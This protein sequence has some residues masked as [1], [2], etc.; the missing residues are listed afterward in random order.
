[1]NSKTCQ[2][3]NIISGILQL[4]YK[5]CQYAIKDKLTGVIKCNALNIM[6]SIVL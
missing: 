3:M 1:M 6:K 4:M 2:I 5:E